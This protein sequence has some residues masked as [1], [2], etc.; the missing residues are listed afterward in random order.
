M[1]KT[2][3]LLVFLMA[4]IGCSSRQPEGTKTNTEGL[5]PESAH[6]SGMQP[7]AA[8]NEKA[9]KF[10]APQGWVSETPTTS[11]RRAQYKLPRVEGDSEDAEL[12][13]YY[14]QGGGGSPQANVERWISQFSKPDGSPAADSAKTSHKE[15]HGIPLTIV[16]VRGNYSG[17]MMSM[18]QSEKPKNNFRML[19]AIAETAS[20]PWFIKLTG[21][22]KTVSKWEPGF[23]TFLDSL[24]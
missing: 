17:S 21:P 7:P 16:D 12:V 22:E 5:K 1:R 20:G 24:R 9:L 14:F 18:Q 2:P 15:A 11:S 13:V 4:L 8:Q 6:G 23:Q 19:A 3:L 10:E